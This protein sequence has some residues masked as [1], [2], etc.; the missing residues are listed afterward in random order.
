MQSK[1]YRNKLKTLCTIDTSDIELQDPRLSTN[2]MTPA[3]QN[4]K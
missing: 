2:I 4:K 3:I 1:N